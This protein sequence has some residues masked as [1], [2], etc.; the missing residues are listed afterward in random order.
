LKAAPSSAT[1]AIPPWYWP[2]VFD[3]ARN[4]GLTRLEAF[5]IL[6]QWLNVTR[7]IWLDEAH[8]ADA[9]SG[10]VRALAAFAGRGVVVVSKAS[11][12]HPFALTLARTV[13]T[14]AKARDAQGKN[15]EI[16]T[17]PAP[18]AAGRAPLSYTT[19]LP[20]N[21]GLI[22]PAFDAATDNEAVSVLARVFP[23]RTIRSVP[24]MI[25]A[26]A[27]LTLAS[28]AVPHPARLL[29]RD[30]ATVLPRSAWSQPAPDVDAML[31]K[32]IDLAERE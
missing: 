15:L 32:Y 12:D 29:E 20:I 4:P 10:D 25:F 23:G 30:R 24:A 6:Q 3:P 17:V 13:S 18:P 11:S 26:E 27:G 2:A 9:L 8:P 21:G 31:Q 14:L 5:A 16:V 19:F 22:V 28:L 1:A 7:V